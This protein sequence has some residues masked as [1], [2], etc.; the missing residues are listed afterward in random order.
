MN[1]TLWEQVLQF[2]FDIPFS[3][4][5][6]STRLANENKWTKSFTS[7]AIVEYK[8]FMYLAATSGYMVS[9]S[10]IV[11]IVWHQHLI[12][13]QSYQDFCV[14]LGKQIQHIPSTHSKH[15]ADKFKEASERTQKL[16]VANF[17]EQPKSIWTYNSMLGSLNLDAAKLEFKGGIIV[18]LLLFACV[19]VPAYFFLRLMYIT[20][21]NPD[22]IINFIGLACI[23]FAGLEVFNRLK[24]YQVTELFD[25]ASFIFHLEPFE[26]IYL[27]T[28][29]LSSILNGTI[30]EL[31]DA[32]RVK[33]NNDK[34]IELLPAEEA[35]S[36]QSSEHLQVISQLND[37]AKI[38]YILLM[39]QLAA[40]PVFRNTANCM[41]A[42][43]KHIVNS[44]KFRNLFY[45]NFGILL[46]LLLFGVIRLVTGI[47]RDKPIVFI[48]LAV[49]VLA[50]L[51]VVYLN[52]L[53]SLMCTNTL[54]YLYKK[55]ILPS[56]KVE[57]N[58]QWSYF[59]LGSAALKTSLVA[60]DKFMER[61]NSSG[62]MSSCGASSDSSCGSS[63]SSCGGCGGD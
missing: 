12:F 34:T 2:D 61:K 56:R 25:K 57:H 42:F 24:L 22:F 44:K 63:C 48:A 9:P 19:S 6:F 16:Y 4:Y 3:E 60:L 59:L 15:E 5:G 26:I 36:T 10:E 58:W 50:V 49:V 41:N 8:K 31:V 23:T 29:K 7:L 46:I 55:K 30:N 32:K 37:A 51:A 35:E 13:S 20:I 33:I 28:E 54:P 43:K 40:K 47:L 53:S 62:G 14:L 27:K 39:Q 11:D 21:D 38:S 45:V 17:G 52:R 1:N 18:G